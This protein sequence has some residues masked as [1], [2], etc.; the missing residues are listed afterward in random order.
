MNATERTHLVTDPAV[1]EPDDIVSSRRS[2]LGTGVVGAG[3]LG[4]AL[5]LGVSRQAGAAAPGTVSESDRELTR[6]A[7]GL[8]LAARD[9]YQAAIDAGAVGTAWPLLRQQHAGYAERLAALVGVSANTRNDAVYEQLK[10]AFEETPANAGFSLENV[11]AA[12]HIELLGLLDDVKVAEIVA[13]VVA[14]ESRHAAYL[15]TV[16]GRGDDLDALFSNPAEPL[17]PE[18]SS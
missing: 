11:A 13:A 6:F 8:E 3:V 9:L 5:A 14:M 10:P 18:T 7:V 2:L 1:A 4:A 12:T 15:A 16:S 17:A